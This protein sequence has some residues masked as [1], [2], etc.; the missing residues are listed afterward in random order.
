MS[1][2][3]KVLISILTGVYRSSYFIFAKILGLQY[4]VIAGVCVCVCAKSCMHFFCRRQNRWWET[5]SCMPPPY[6]V[7]TRVPVIAW[8]KNSRQL[9]ALIVALSLCY[10]TPR[11]HRNWIYLQR[12]RCNGAGKGMHTNHWWCEHILQYIHTDSGHAAAV[13]HT[14]KRE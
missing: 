2:R 10:P 12:R 9:V 14:R 8:A 6:W 5:M 7:I 3:I 4:V 1:I 11:L 13:A